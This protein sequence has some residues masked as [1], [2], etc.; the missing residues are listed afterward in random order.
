MLI[1]I[2]CHLFQHFISHTTYRI[3]TTDLHVPNMAKDLQNIFEEQMSSH[4]PGS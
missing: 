4:I 2:L 1:P 3:I